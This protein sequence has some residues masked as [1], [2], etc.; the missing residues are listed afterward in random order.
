MAGLM[1]KV[2][3]MVEAGVS[4]PTAIK[5]ALGISVSE[6]AAKH[7]LV[8]STAAGQIN[9]LVR[10]DEKIATALSTEVGGTVDEWLDLLWH[11]TRPTRS[12]AT[13]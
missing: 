3:Q 13:A 5:E 6:F 1:D 10:A 11:A 8:R 12:S 9:G 4:I 7:G 2:K